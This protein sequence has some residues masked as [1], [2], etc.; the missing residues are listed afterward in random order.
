MHIYLDLVSSYIN[1]SLQN[2]V[3]MRKTEKWYF[4]TI[5]VLTYCEQKLF[6]CEERNEKKV[7]KFEAVRARICNV[8]KIFVPHTIEQFFSQLVRNIMVTD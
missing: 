6:Y 2:D 1:A 3:K 5:I 7:C 8:F 4:V